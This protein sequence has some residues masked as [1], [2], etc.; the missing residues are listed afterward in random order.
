ML[1]PSRP[2]P[3]AGQRALVIGGGIGGLAVGIGL[4]R[5]GF[6]VRVYEQAPQL[7]PVGA[8]ITIWANAVK[9]LRQLGLDAA[10]E[11]VRAPE[12]TGDIF[13]PS[14]ARLSRGKTAAQTYGARSLTLPRPE[15]HALL[16]AQLGAEHLTLNA[17]L[18][19]FEQTE[20]GVVARFSD[21]STAQGELLVGA[22]GLYSRVRAQLFGAGPPRYAGYAAWYAM[23]PFDHA[24]LRAGG[25][26]C[27][28]ATAR[29]PLGTRDPDGERAGLLRRFAGWHTP[30]PDL[31]AATPERHIIRTDIYERPS[32]R[33]WSAGRATLLGDAAH[34]MPPNLGQGAC[35]AIED[36]VTLVKALRQE[37]QI[38]SALRLYERRRAGRTTWVYQQVRQVGQV[39]HWSHPLAVWGRDLLLRRALAPL[40]RAV[41]G[42]I[43]G[44]EA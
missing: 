18:D 7:H 44:H 24:R 26:V 37:R 40:Q 6:E 8:G 16:L 29:Q 35:Q 9:G 34:P 39:A 38:E 33:R 25:Q 12:M 17:H 20:G 19:S 5:L 14:G 30:I 23:V 11:R 15:L 2:A 41:L 1:H 32:L 4:R 3:F 28:F 27:W 13:N 31:I 36:A 42:D 21:G 22:D 10:L 43:W